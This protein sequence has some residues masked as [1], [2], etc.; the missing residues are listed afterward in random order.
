MLVFMHYLA[1]NSLSIA[2]L[3]KER[4][5]FLKMS[6]YLNGKGISPILIVEMWN[7]PF[8]IKIGDIFEN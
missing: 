7:T 4:D 5:Q 1:Q 6:P 3:R 8:L 2:A